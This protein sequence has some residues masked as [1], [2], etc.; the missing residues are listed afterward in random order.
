MDTQN[1]VIASDVEV[2]GRHMVHLDAGIYYLEVNAEGDII[3]I[4]IN[5]LNFD[6]AEQNII[7]AEGI[8]HFTEF[9]FVS[10]NSFVF[11]PSVSSIYYL[12]IS[13]SSTIIEFD[14]AVSDGL[15]IVEIK[16]LRLSPLP[17]DTLNQRYAIEAELEKG[18]T[19]YINVFC[20][21]I[22]SGG[23]RDADK[24]PVSVGVL[25]SVPNII[26]DVNL[27]ATDSI[28]E[29]TVIKDGKKNGIK[30]VS[31]GRTY[32]I[33]TPNV[34]KVNCRLNEDYE[35]CTIKGNQLIIEFNSSILDNL[36]EIVFVDDTDR[37]LIASVIIKYPYY[38]KAEFDESNWQFSTS[39]IDRYGDANVSDG[40]IKSTN[41]N[42][43]NVEFKGFTGSKVSVL[44]LIKENP[45]FLNGELRFESEIEVVYAGTYYYTVRSDIVT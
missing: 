6:D 17:N 2:N 44:S 45:A 24:S 25:I 20:N 14:I 42:I 26:G 19:Y 13:Y 40:I 12:K 15:N 23:I 30:T 27:S 9:S 39:L 43:G 33:E 31:M 36:I 3:G 7:L 8:E 21:G 18:K 37:I 10:D 1:N 22:N 41:L 38:A 35:G 4:C 28:D 34:K 5:S 16:E 29:I 32:I 11:T